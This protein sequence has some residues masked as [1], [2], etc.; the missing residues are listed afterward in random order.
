M[1]YC[2][3]SQNERFSGKRTFIQPDEGDEGEHFV[4]DKADQGVFGVST[5]DIYGGMLFRR[6]LY[7]K[8]PTV[9]GSLSFEETS[10]IVS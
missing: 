1:V 10:R 3:S 8:P 5:I 9:R 6:C 2:S 4:N 7:R